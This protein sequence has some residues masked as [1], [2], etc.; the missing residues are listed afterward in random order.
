MVGWR[1]TAV[2]GAAGA[3][4]PL[5]YEAARSI[6]AVR[7]LT[8]PVQQARLL[9]APVK[10]Q[11]HSRISSQVRFFITLDTIRPG[12]KFSTG[13]W[14]LGPWLIHGV[15]VDRAID[16]LVKS[17]KYPLGFPGGV[18]RDSMPMMPGRGYPEFGKKN[19]ASSAQRPLNRSDPRMGPVPRH[20]SVGEF[21]GGR[22]HSASNLQNFF[23]NQ[24]YGSRPNDGDQ[25]MQARRR[26][27]AQRERELRNYHQEQQYHKR[28]LTHLHSAETQA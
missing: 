10:S 25:A 23:A 8:G 15:E 7:R 1:T 4:L 27:A 12:R 3:A 16:N 13:H 21:D 28:R 24:R 26:A 14:Q 20:H 18:R 11:T 9:Q 19:S 5:R 6:H 17:G 2:V 22:S